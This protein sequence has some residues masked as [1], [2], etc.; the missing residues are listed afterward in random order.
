MYFLQEVLGKLDISPYVFKSV[1]PSENYK[2]G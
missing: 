2:E 1:L